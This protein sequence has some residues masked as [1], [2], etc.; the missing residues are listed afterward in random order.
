MVM[1][2]AMTRTHGLALIVG[3]LAVALVSFWLSFTQWAQFA[4][5]WHVYVRDGQVTVL[6]LLVALGGVFVY[7]RPQKVRR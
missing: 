7:L 5:A 2:G 3:G 4:P 1:D 6:A